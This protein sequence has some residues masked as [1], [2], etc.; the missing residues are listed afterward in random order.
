MQGQGLLQRATVPTGQT[1]G[2]PRG[3][4]P[5]WVAGFSAVVTT[6]SEVFAHP[7]I[8]GSGSY[9]AWIAGPKMPARTVPGG[10]W[11]TLMPSAH[12]P[13][14]STRDRVAMRKMSDGM[15]MSDARPIPL[16][17]PVTT[18]IFPARQ[19]VTVGGADSMNVNDGLMNVR[20][21]R[22]RRLWMAQVRFC[23]IADKTDRGLRQG[24]GEIT[25]PKCRRTRRSKSCA[26][27]TSATTGCKPGEA[28][29]AGA[30]T[31]ALPPYMNRCSPAF[32]PPRIT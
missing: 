23:Q 18:A 19:A 29:A 11:M 26:L 10:I 20:P 17:T 4:Q 6:S 9:P 3:A 30:G 7:P 15:S 16:P 14:A 5:A 24:G 8:W 1:E 27:A 32:S 25:T 13:Y 21:K 28:R 31:A 22:F 2:L 12:N